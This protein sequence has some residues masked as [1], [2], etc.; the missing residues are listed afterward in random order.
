MDASANVLNFANSFYLLGSYRNTYVQFTFSDE[1]AECGS[2]RIENDRVVACVEGDSAIVGRNLQVCL[3]V[4][5]AH[6]CAHKSDLNICEFRDQQDTEISVESVGF[7]Q[8]RRDRQAFLNV[9]LPRVKRNQTADR[10]KGFAD[11]T[12]RA[13]N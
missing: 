7:G 4:S 5:N 13:S 9:Q 2:D 1:N 11:E 10:I 12:R 3:A 8:I 6:Q